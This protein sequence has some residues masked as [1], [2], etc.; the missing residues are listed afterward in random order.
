[1]RRGLLVLAAMALT[2]CAGTVC[3]HPVR[4]SRDAFRGANP[5]LGE[6]LC[7]EDASGASCCTKGGK[8]TCK[9]DTT[10]PCWRNPDHK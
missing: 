5:F 10:C 3:V 4:G 7:R 2:G 9:C 1:M 8:Y 6:R